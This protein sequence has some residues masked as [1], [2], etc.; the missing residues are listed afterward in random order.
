MYK[1]WAVTQH[2][3]HAIKVLRSD[4]GGEYLSQAFNQ[5]LASAGTV[6]RLTTHDMPQ[7]NGITERLNRTLLERIHAFSHTSSLP[8]SLWGKALRQATWLKNRTSTR[9]LDGKTPFEALYGRSPDLSALRTWG[10]SMLVHN[11]T[12]SKL[13][14]HTREARWL[15]L[16]VDA[17]AHRVYWPHTGTV[18]V[19]RN[20]YFGTSAP[21]EGEEEDSPGAGN[22]LAAEP[23]T[24]TSLTPTDPNAQPSPPDPP[25]PAIDDEPESKD[26]G[27][28][29][30]PEP[31]QH[32]PP[33]LL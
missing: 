12:G 30:E 15:G 32:K 19:E 18:G 22:E 14:A 2:H 3:C 26:E 24:P 28:T 29:P 16:D 25:S 17:K 4:R 6:R 33:M 9:S 23:P 27:N 8:K 1:A 31:E 7:L 10:I 13:D 21:L 11:A 20:V 5:H